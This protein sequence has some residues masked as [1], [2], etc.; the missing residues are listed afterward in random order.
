MLIYEKFEYWD[1][2]AWSSDMQSSSSTAYFIEGAFM[3][4]DVFYSPR[5][6]T[7]II[8]YMTVYADS[9][10][11]YR[12]LEADQGILPPFAP[13][14]DSS[15]DYVENILK[16]SWSEQQL[17]FKAN[18]GLSGK[19]IYS[20]GAH[21]G[22]YGSNDIINGGTKIL[23]SW[24]SPTGLDPSTLTSEYQIVTAEVDFV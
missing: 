24:T 8:V 22:Y 21:L 17:L 18:P 6:L 13:G 9:T 7:F 12:Y 3:D 23:L 1:G 5:H 14:G 4:I 20:G 11:Y 10:F 16:Y 19:Y 2:S 15:S